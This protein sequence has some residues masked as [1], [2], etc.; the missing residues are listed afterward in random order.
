MKESRIWKGELKDTLTNLS[1]AQ[2]E[3]LESAVIH[4]VGLTVFVHDPAVPMDNN[5]A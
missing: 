5:R 2:R 1:S 3:V 4:W